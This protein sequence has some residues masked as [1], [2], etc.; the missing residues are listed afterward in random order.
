MMIK[1][2]LKKVNLDWVNFQVMRRT[3]IGWWWGSII[4][5][6]SVIYDLLAL[7]SNMTGSMWRKCEVLRKFGR[8]KP[9]RIMES[10][11]HMNHSKQKSA[12]LHPLG[13]SFRGPV[14]H[15]VVH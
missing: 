3:H 12:A 14:R 6:R 7:T 11:R 9:M 15:D 8:L 13:G 1:P 5:I 4:L 2:K 10:P